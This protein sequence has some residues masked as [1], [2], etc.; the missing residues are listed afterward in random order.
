MM[1]RRRGGRLIVVLVVG[2]LGA[3]AVAVVTPAGA[4]EGEP[5]AFV[6]V[7]QIPNRLSLV[8][9][10][11][12]FSPGSPVRIT[13]SGGGGD[14]REFSQRVRDDT[15]FSWSPDR[16][17]PCRLGASDLPG[18]Q[19]TVSVEVP[20]APYSLDQPITL[21]PDTTKPRFLDPP[22]DASPRPGSKVEVGDKIDFEVTATDKTPAPSWQTGVHSLQV[23]G[24]QGL[25]GSKDGGR[26]P[27]ACGDK[28]KSLTVQGTHRVKRSDPPVIELCAITEDYVP[29][30]NN[31]CAQ[32]YKGEVWEGT[33]TTTFHHPECI[34]TATSPVQFAVKGESGKFETAFTLTQVASSCG[35]QGSWGS[36]V[37]PGRVTRNA[38]TTTAFP[39]FDGRIARSG[40]RINGTYTNPVGDGT[41]FETTWELQCVSCGD[42]AVG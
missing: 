26:L 32:W 38:M 42:E 21:D 37:V 41:S 40:D 28:S 12:Y 14:S 5:G 34:S 10:G 20:S 13:F 30:E 8:S 27:K 19:F 11:C 33:V 4:Q 23:T 9:E 24:P 36:P 1:R 17:D 18:T 7:N 3:A 39:G 22:F 25:L 35:G 29:N 2:A 16:L 31:K 6:N 15:C